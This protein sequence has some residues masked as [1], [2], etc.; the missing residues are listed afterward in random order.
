MSCS[1]PMGASSV[2]TW[3]WS[4]DLEQRYSFCDLERMLLS[5]GAFETEEITCKLY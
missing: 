1:L 3:D 4:G 5:F 2:T